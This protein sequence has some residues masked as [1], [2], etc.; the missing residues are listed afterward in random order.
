MISN[1]QKFYD[2]HF[3]FR[4]NSII[5]Q[6]SSLP[7]ESVMQ[8]CLKMNV[9]S[10]WFSE[11]EYNYSAMLLE[12]ETPNPAGCTD[13][14]LRE[15]FHLFREK[16]IS[17]L[18]INFLAARARGLL[19]FKQEKRFCAKCGGTLHDDPNFTARTC[20]KCSK[21]YFPQ[22][23]PAV[24][25]LVSRKN[26]IG[27]EELLLAR[28]KNRNDGMFSCIAGFV[29]I[30]ETIE[31]AVKREILEETNLKVKNIRYVG[32]QAWPFPDQ[33][34]LAFRAEYESGSIKIQESEIAE[35]NWFTR[36]NL[37]LIPSPGSVAYN[38]IHGDF[39]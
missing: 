20:A 2:L 22:L 8:K 31:N 10:D 21:Q 11:P 14:P 26:E 7:D 35:A 29:E 15:F 23:E 3:I 39:N 4:E 28:H 30:G 18:K 27:A 38:L 1:S 13:I 33:L 32:S 34:M 6:D 9:A 12:S 25:T 17:G 36:E 16:E 19:H 37:P 24:I 5:L